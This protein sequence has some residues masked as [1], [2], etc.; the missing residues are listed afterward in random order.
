MIEVRVCDSCGH[1]NSLNSTFCENGE[2]GEDI[3]FI[4]PTRIE[5][6]P[7]PVSNSEE[8]VTQNTMDQAPSQSPK[9]MR[10]TGMRLINTASGY[11][12]TIPF[13][14]GVL[15]RSGTIQSEHFLNSLFVSNHHARIQLTDNG[16]VLVDLNSTNG[17][18]IN[19]AK[20][21]SGIEHPISV[22]TRITL[23]NL[24]YIIQ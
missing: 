17:T 3:L 5:D 11:E 20:I 12:I 2:C 9:T 1:R 7:L 15:G 6:N 24:E 8:E 13:E 14:G 4:A 16:Y 23:A 19:G 18:K 21:K 10:M 22:G